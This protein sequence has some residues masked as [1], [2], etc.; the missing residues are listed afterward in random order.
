MKKLCTLIG[1][2]IVRAIVV[3]SVSCAVFSQSIIVNSSDDLQAMIDSSTEGDELFL[4]AGTYVGNFEVTQ[5]ISLYGKQG[6]KFNANGMN[7]AL[8][9]TA[10]NVT[11]K[12]MSLFN[13][14]DDLTETNAAIKAKNVEHLTLENN[15]LQGNG[16][17]FYLE[18]VR[19]AFIKN[20]DVTGNSEMRSADRGNGIHLTNV[21]QA[22]VIENK[23]THTRDG[24]YIINSQNNKLL[25]N[26][27]SDLRFGIHYMY[28]HNNTV[29]GN[30]TEDIDV[31]YALMSSNNLIIENNHANRARD[32]GLLLNFVNTSKF[33]NNTMD[34]ISPGSNVIMGDEGK[35]LFVY[36]SNNN[37]LESNTFSNSDM[38]IHLTAGSE[39]NKI[40]NNQFV[41]NEIQVKYVSSRTQEWSNDG[42]GNYWSNYIGWDLDRNGIGDT[43]FEPNDD[44]DKLIWKYPEAKVI[45][46]SPAVLLLRWVQRSFPILKS[47]GVKD[48]FP[49]FQFK[50]PTQ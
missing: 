5:S 44:I 33:T 31:G 30:I 16:F 18:G 26:H 48:S 6:V 3:G 28:S 23:V 36:N 49:Q 37:H 45:M 4:Q 12:N 11:I 10:N 21:K 39:N 15:T 8:T 32:Y 9:I 41:N 38:G 1:R 29:S 7:N 50:G 34:H 46:D 40:F 27:M 20:N 42:Q 25:N 17:G 19:T 43:A 13:W 47:P 14:G 24:L 22:T 2:T 35:A